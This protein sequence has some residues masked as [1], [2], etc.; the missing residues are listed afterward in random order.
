MVLGLKVLRSEVRG[1]RSAIRTGPHRP[2]SHVTLDDLSPPLGR[3]GSDFSTL[4]R[5]RR[6]PYNPHSIN[7]TFLDGKISQ[8]SGKIAEFLRS[9]DSG[10]QTI[11]G[12]ETNALEIH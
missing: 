7:R 4:V 8:R 2:T 1:L 6:S 9:S 3:M 10:K 12:L 5:L 11:Q